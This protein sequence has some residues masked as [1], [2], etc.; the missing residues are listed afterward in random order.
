M[1]RNDTHSNGRLSR[2]NFLP[3]QTRPLLQHPTKA[4]RD[5]VKS[6][7]ELLHQK[8]KS[9][10][11]ESKPNIETSDTKWIKHLCEHYKIQ[12]RFTVPKQVQRFSAPDY[13]AAISINNHFRKAFNEMIDY[14]ESHEKTFSPEQKLE[15][16]KL[17]KLGFIKPFKNGAAIAFSNYLAK[18]DKYYIQTGKAL[19]PSDRQ[20]LLEAYYIWGNLEVNPGLET[21]VH[22]LRTQ[23]FQLPEILTEDR[24]KDSTKLYN[25]SSFRRR[26]NNR[27]SREMPL[28]ELVPTVR[29]SRFRTKV[30]KDKDGKPVLINRTP[31]VDGRKK[32]IQAE[33]DSK[34]RLRFIREELQKHETQVIKPSNPETI[35]LS[36]DKAKQYVTDYYNSFMNLGISNESLNGFLNGIDPGPIESKFEEKDLLK[37][38]SNKLRIFRYLYELK[39][40]MLIFFIN[41]LGKVKSKKSLPVLERA[42][43]DILA[44]P[45]NLTKR[46]KEF[47]ILCEHLL[48]ES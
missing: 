32:I 36:F 47:L 15:L 40:S 11:A 18:L 44:N 48:I 14:Y 10:A 8:E 13:Y 34:K 5:R 9:Q 22:Y 30:I 16:S 35:T 26:N 17:Y 2:T 27:K 33:I 21:A 25:Q 24:S 42:L 46:Q 31:R 7:Q 3:Q 12:P 38:F 43:G 1:I 28:I 4:S 41:D 23:D 45:D 39:R 29:P 6:P 20:A 19:K 37:E